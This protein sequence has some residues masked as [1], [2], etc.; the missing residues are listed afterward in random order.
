LKPPTPIRILIVEDFHAETEALLIELRDAEMTFDKIIVKDEKGY[1]DGLV[2]FK[3]DII[4]SPYSLKGT[5]AIKLLGI[6]KKL[7]VEAPF[8]LLAFDLSEDIAIDLLVEGIE[9]YVQES[10]LKRLPV[11]IKKALQRHKTQLEL[12]ISEKRLRASKEALRSMVSNAP[13]AVAMF[14]INM[15]YLVVSETWLAHENKTQDVI[16]KN[17]YE[18]I[19]ET[20]DSWK[21]IHKKVLQGE[22]HE[23]E[24]EKMLRTNGKLRMVR[25]KMNPWFNAD[26]TV[27]GAVLFIEDI[28]EKALAQ[29]ALEQSEANLKDAQVLGQLGSWE[30]NLETYHIEWSDQ[31][32]AMH[33]LKKQLVTIEL[34]MG[35]IHPDDKE[36]VEAAINE[37]LTGE[38]RPLRYRIIRADT[39]EERTVQGSGGKK[40]GNRI[41]GTIADVT[42][43]VQAQIRIEKSESLLAMGEDLSGSGS[44]EFDLTSETK[45]WSEGM[46][47]IKG[48]DLTADVSLDSYIKHI[49]PEDLAAYL[50]TYTKVLSHVI[51]PFFEYRLIRPDNGKV[52]H[53]LVHGAFVNNKKGE[54][55]V[56]MGSV[57]DV[58]HIRQADMALLESEA[59]LKTAQRIAKLGSWVHNAETSSSEWSD[60]MFS[61]YGI[62]K[63]TVKVELS[64][65]LI[66]P[67]DVLMRDM[68]YAKLI[69]G[70]NTNMVF[71]IFPANSDEIKYLHAVGRVTKN[72]DGDITNISGTIQ[73]ITE[74]ELTSVEL[75]RSEASLKTAQKLA[76]VGSWEWS[77]STEFLK[78]SDEIYSMYETIKKNLT[79]EDM[80][81]FIHPED[82]ERVAKEAAN[83]FD[84]KIKHVIEYR[85]ITE[86]G[87]VK[88][89]V[90]TAKQ[91]FDSQGNVAQLV[92]V[93]QDI[94]EITLERK[95]RETELLQRELAIHASNVGIWHWIIGE[96]AMFWDKRSMEIF[97]VKKGKYPTDNFFNLIHA[98]DRDYVKE[99]I[100]LALKTGNYKANYR[101]GKGKNIRYLYVEGKASVGNDGQAVR[102]D[103]IVQDVTRQRLL[104][105]ELSDKEGVLREMAENIG[106]VFWITDLAKNKVLYITPQYESLYEVPVQ[107]IY[108]DPESWEKR[109][110]PEDLPRIAKAFREAAI[111]GT[112]DEEC[113][114]LM[115]DGR[116]KWVRDRAFPIKDESGKVVRMAGI[117]EDITGKKKDKEQIKTLSLVASE[118]I[119][120]VLIQ[121]T[122]GKIEWTNKGFT[123]ITGY[124]KE[125]VVGRKPW[126]FLAG[127]ETDLKLAEL[128]YKKLKEGKSSTTENTLY[129]KAGK[130]VWV[131]LAVSP[132]F[133]SAGKLSRT[134]A[135]ATDISKQKEL[136]ELQ[137]IML[138]RME[139]HV[140]E[141]TAELKQKNVELR[142][143]MWE[144]QRISD[145]LYHHNLDLK[146]SIEYAKRIQE[147]TLPDVK[148]LQ[149]SFTHGFVLFLPRDIVSGDFY[150]YYKRGNLSYFAAIDCTGHGVPGALM[151]MIANEL[152]NQAIIQEKL[153]DPGE[154]L[155]SLNK[156]MIRTLRQKEGSRMRDGMDLSLIVLNQ[157]SGSLNFSGALSSMY[158]AYKNDIAFYPGSRHSVG[159][160]LE[161]VKKTF[162]TTQIDLQKGSTIYLYTDGYID[163]FGGPE[164]KKLMKRRFAAFLESIQNLPLGEQKNAL[165]E[166]FNEWKGTLNQ[167][168]DVLVAGL[169][170]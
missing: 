54:P 37:S 22:T 88:Y 151:S 19:P 14:D 112:Y 78:L 4:L 150:W 31:M 13:I 66:H 91:V 5:N 167:V 56:L 130:P 152:M 145:E 7:D 40:T 128:T 76:K 96:D 129:S 122:T 153:T 82:K 158:I 58:T 81:G 15:N 34:Y 73:D 9:D 48:F 165:L 133:D 103:G 154:I 21:D 32:F 147:S 77:K 100:T 63:Q 83:D 163:Q 149:Q 24:N 131:S 57:Q 1:K 10:T 144:S 93:Y 53:L 89:V 39:G 127:E 62:E 108:D 135:V 27:G 20:L 159:G 156:L 136:E 25:W 28:T 17:H 61:I 121:G 169:S 90:T 118:T 67:D 33:G 52:V 87:N 85:I 110:H 30:M 75:K 125:E 72:E 84:D 143:E 95:T 101:I 46:Y 71:R 47:K 12:R 59:S 92:G 42:E 44:F 45:R 26:G 106:E 155:S 116:V 51:P 29:S 18:V 148:S 104:E 161:D 139:V 119:N 105:Q 98:D 79:I 107:T 16:G 164:G 142:E 126:A 86:K 50:A 3:P 70:E 36:K 115:P 157:D 6:A 43:T 168:D 137:R 55:S 23:S 111:L 102:L 8:I 117:T 114:L 97:G 166:K 68:L 35:I 170:Y 132:I 60:E 138:T 69:G 49:H 109:M 80:R 141:R 2:S 38:Y 65:S 11:A 124:S 113:R 74:Q 146:D 94:T 120:G 41:I 160:H 64:R 162:D 140:A 123:K 134:V 99:K